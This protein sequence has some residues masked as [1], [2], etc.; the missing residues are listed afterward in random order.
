MFLI[1]KKGTGILLC[2]EATE[3][4]L[5]TVYA[6]AKEEYKELELDLDLVF[7]KPNVEIVYNIV[8]FVRILDSIVGLSTYSKEEDTKIETIELS[9]SE[10]VEIEDVQE[11][12]FEEVSLLDESEDLIVYEE[13]IEEPINFS[14]EDEE[15]TYEVEISLEEPIVEIQEPKVVIEEVEVEI[16]EP[17]KGEEAPR[18]PNTPGDR[19]MES[20][21]E[22]QKVEGLLE[23]EG[24]KVNTLAYKEHLVNYM[25]LGYASGLL[26]K[27]IKDCNDTSEQSRLFNFCEGVDKRTEEYEIRFKQI[28]L[29]TG[30]VYT[31]RMEVLRDIRKYQDDSIKQ[32]CEYINKLYSVSDSLIAILK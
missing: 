23:L 21:K 30:Q 12:E 7:D 29:T 19:M 27:K 17:V 2:L 22:Q 18:V 4:I 6:S 5:A 8:R 9:I 3:A 24:D 28:G 26:K 11:G 20:L 14:E 31:F 15:D 25:K 32:I 1:V 16:D 13:E 10:A